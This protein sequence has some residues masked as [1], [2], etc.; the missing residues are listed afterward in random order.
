MT[1]TRTTASNREVT[2]ALAELVGEQCWAIVAGPD[3]GS[4]ILLDLGARLPR[5]HELRNPTL[6]DEERRFEASY[7]IHVWCSWRVEAEG[8]V[9]GSSLALP[10]AGWWERSGLARI[11]GRRLIAFDLQEPIPDLRLDFGEAT[12]AMFADTLSEDDED[13]AFTLRT[14]DGILVAFANGELQREQI[15][16]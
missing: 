12:L 5:Q 1:T 4:V 10:E 16:F 8:R 15:L 9:V 14:S 7:S 6:A 2:A 13:C 11:K 3:T